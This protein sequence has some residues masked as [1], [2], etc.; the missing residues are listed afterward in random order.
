MTFICPLL[1]ADEAKEDAEDWFDKCFTSATDC[2]TSIAIQLQELKNKSKVV[3]AVLLS[4][5]PE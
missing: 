5:D 1:K 3:P 4:D 2:M